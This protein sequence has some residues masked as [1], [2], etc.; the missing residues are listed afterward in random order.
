MA[1]IDLSPF[2][3]TSGRVYKGKISLIPAL[4]RAESSVLRHNFS[5]VFVASCTCPSDIA[6]PP[7]EGHPGGSKLSCHIVCDVFQVPCFVLLFH[8]RHNKIAYLK[9]TILSVD[10]PC[11]PFLR[12]RTTQIKD[13]CVLVCSAVW[14]GKELLTTVPPSPTCLQR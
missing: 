11:V 1:D 2:S 7:K 4:C 6:D 12:N 14:T 13:A 10:T 5:F 8:H 9:A 3:V